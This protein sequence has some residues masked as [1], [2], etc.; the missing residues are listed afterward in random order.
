[1]LQ[2]KRLWVTVLGVVMG[3]LNQKLGLNLGEAELLFVAG[4][5]GTYIVGSAGKSAV[6]LK[7][8]A[9]A[10]GDAAR[11]EVKDLETALEVLKGAK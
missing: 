2:D 7:E 4:L 8:Q 5:I 6:V 3:A 10:K 11:A 9:K 1:M